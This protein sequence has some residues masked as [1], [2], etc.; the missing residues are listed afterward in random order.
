MGAGPSL[1]QSE[2]HIGAVGGAL[3]VATA[4]FARPADTTAYA[5]N[6]AVSN[7]DPSVLMTFAGLARVAGG[8]GYITKAR[9]VTDQSANT[10]AFRLWL[11]TISNP[12]VAADNA[13]FT[14]SWAN[15]ANRIG[16]I[17]FPALATEGT[18][19]DSASALADTIRL[20]FQCAA[21]SQALY[22]LL[23]TKSAFTPANAQNFYVELTAEQN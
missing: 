7:G 15:R 18:G 6:D 14:L 5:A 1:G 8:S 12:S 17:D 10:A 21:G 23:E 11:Y 9:I 4:T 13:A 3:V 22:A 2:D 20:A 19:S 16:Y